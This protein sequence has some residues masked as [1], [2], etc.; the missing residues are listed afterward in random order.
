MEDRA[1]AHTDV[2]QARGCRHTKWH[3][4]MKRIKGKNDQGRRDGLRAA[5]SISP[6]LSRRRFTL[7]GAPRIPWIYPPVPL[8]VWHTYLVR[9]T[10]AA[11]QQRVHAHV[12][13]CCTI[14]EMKFKQYTTDP[15]RCVGSEIA[16]NSVFKIYSLNRYWILSNP[17]NPNFRVASSRRFT[18]RA[19]VFTI[20][21]TWTSW[22]IRIPHEHLEFTITVVCRIQL[23]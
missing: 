10:C 12:C 9:S 15:R 5:S 18:P 19:L 2:Q 22:K 1:H 11:A 6:G 17:E 21:Y 7:P 8:V 14:R 4:R 13:S 3:E 16:Y 20:F 23:T